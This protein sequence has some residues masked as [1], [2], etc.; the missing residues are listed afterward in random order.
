MV[1]GSTKGLKVTS[2]NSLP[3]YKIQLA[4]YT[5]IYMLAKYKCLK[6]VIVG[7]LY[8]GHAAWPSRNIRPTIATG[9]VTGSAV[10]I[11]IVR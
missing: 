6:F 3:K 8:S 7:I 11:L 5:M 9:Q 1:Q 4:I 2:T 10:Q